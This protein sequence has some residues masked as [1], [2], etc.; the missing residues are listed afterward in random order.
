MLTLVR[1]IFFGAP[2]E[3]YKEHVWVCEFIQRHFLRREL[4]ALYIMSAKDKESYSRSILPKV[5][6]PSRVTLRYNALSS[7]C[8]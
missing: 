4:D 7:F 2:M 8:G 6:T 1:Q 5:K 3:K